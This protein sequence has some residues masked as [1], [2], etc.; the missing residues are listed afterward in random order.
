MKVRGKVWFERDGE[1]VFGKGRADL[2]RAVQ[3]TGSISAAAEALGMSYRHA[4]SMLN[5][6]AERYGR[7]LVVTERGG[8]EGGGARVTEFGRRLLRLHA[9][10]QSEMEDWLED[11]QNAMDDAGR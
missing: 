3:R 7:A 1:H 11:S 8:A 10:L 6:S 5:S 4:W 9:R 2:L